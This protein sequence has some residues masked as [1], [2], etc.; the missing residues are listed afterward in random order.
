ML[1]PDRPGLGFTTSDQCKAWTVDTAVAERLVQGRGWARAGARVGRAAQGANSGGRAGA[2]Q[3][4]TDREFADG[5]VRGQPDRGSRGDLAAAGGRAG[6]DLPGPRVVRAALP[7]HGSP[8]R[9]RRSARTR[10]CWSCS[11]SGSGVEVEAAGLAAGRRTG[12]QLKAID[13]A[14]DDFRRVG[15]ESRAGSVEADFAFHLKVARASGNRFYSRADRLARADDDHAA[16]HPARPGVRDVRRLPPHPGHRSSTRTSTARSPTPTR[17]RQPRGHAR[18]PVEHPPPPAEVEPSPPSSVRGE[19]RLHGLHVRR[20]VAA[21]DSARQV[22]LVQPPE[23]VLV[24]FDAEPRAGRQPHAAAGEVQYARL[25][26]VLG[27][28]RVVGVARVGEVRESPRP[29]ASS[30]PG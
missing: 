1:V 19:V 10:T 12:H 26:Q 4:A 27:L 6:G 17:E 24:E 22:L 5:G 13:R 7:E 8:R 11:T 25:D 9:S 21:P 28:P 15:D 18:A 16:A 2:G 20:V 3:Q 23:R 14:L 29:V 30:P